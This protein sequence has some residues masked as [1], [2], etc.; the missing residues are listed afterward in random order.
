[1]YVQ[2]ASS[3]QSNIL[4]YSNYDELQNQK[5]RWFIETQDKEN[6]KLQEIKS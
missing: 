1:M 3:L 4:V 6:Q 2:I 5:L